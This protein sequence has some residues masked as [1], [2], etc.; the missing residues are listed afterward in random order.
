VTPLGA[1]CGGVAELDVLWTEAAGT[2]IRTGSG[3][4][5]LPRL[6]GERVIDP[7]AWVAVMVH[8][9]P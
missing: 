2:W 3:C 8:R 1:V 5:I 9:S 6:A 7:S 4:L